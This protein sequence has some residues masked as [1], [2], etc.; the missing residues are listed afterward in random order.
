MDREMAGYI[1]NATAN[2]LSEYWDFEIFPKLA[3][4]KK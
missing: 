3:P 4:A 2:K 1:I